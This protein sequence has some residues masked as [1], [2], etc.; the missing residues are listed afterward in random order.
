MSLC[1]ESLCQMSF[2]LSVAFLL[3]LWVSLCWMLLMLNAAYA[4]C[5]LCWMLLMLNAAYAECCLCWMLL[6]LNADYAECCL[7]WMLLMLNAAYA[8][9]WDIYW[10]AHC[11]S[12]EMSFMIHVIYCYSECHYTECCS[13]YLNA[14]CWSFCWL[15]WRCIL[16]I[17]LNH[18][19]SLCTC[20]LMQNTSSHKAILW[21]T[22]IHLTMHF[23]LRRR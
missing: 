3:L 18:K 9:F 1:W 10:Y 15:S 19:G 6:M 11:C 22:S 7:C 2:M 17:L 21:K 16:N 5:C 23:L 14:Y 12:A 8:E 20:T 4:E 13:F